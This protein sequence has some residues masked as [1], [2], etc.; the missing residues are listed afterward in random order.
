M[1]S[2]R[3]CRLALGLVL[4]GVAAG[5]RSLPGPPSLLDG[6]LV[7]SPAPLPPDRE[8]AAQAHAFYSIGIHHELAG[9]Y[10]PAYD[11]YRKAAEFDPGNERLVLRMASTL[12]LQRKTED[13]LRAV[14]DFL[15]RNPGSE[16]ALLWLATF[17]GSTGDPARVVELF[18]RMTRQFP[19]KPL[20]WLQLAAA[21]ARAGDT[22]AVEKILENGL[23]KAKPPTA[24]R[25]ELVRIQLARMAAAED[26][27]R[28]NEARRQAIALLRQIAGELPGDMDTLYALGD[29]LV[30]DGQLGEAVL[31]Y[32]KIE[33][34]QPA[35]LQV[36][37][38]LA[39]T[40]LAM[41][42][43]PKA[44]AVLEGLARERESPSNIHYYLAE[45]YLQSG[46]ATN[47]VAH[48]RTAADAS[49]GDPAPW[50][51]LAA[52][53]AEDNEEAAVAT[54]SEA[55]EKMP[56]DPK[57]LEVLALVRQQQKRYE[58]AA[59]LMQQAYDAVVA[60]DPDA[61]P[62]NLFFYNY[63]I[64][65]THLRQ[66]KD[67]AR[68][69]QRASE[70]EPALL[71]LYMQR[72]LTGTGTFRK[73]A[74]GVLRALAKLP[75]TESATIHTHLANLYLSQDRADRAIREFEAAIEIAKKEPLQAT[76]LTPRFYFWFGVA[77][78]Q[79][80]QPERAV[81]MFE[82]CLSLD[83]EYA[84]ALNYLAYLW[85]VRG[86]R[87]DDALGHIQTALALDPENAAYLDTLGWVYYQQGR[88]AD[89]LQLLEQA[90][91]LR[92]EDPEI[93]DHLQKTREKLAP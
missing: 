14:E 66:S 65:C 2:A 20:G 6:G 85:A 48:F 34:L 67:A 51:K 71:E 19:S 64:L 77:L 17:Y 61:I 75:S 10:A 63:A 27:A 23:S 78:D 42:D 31:T 41:D 53:Q 62:S 15:E 28:K 16:G 9:E 57:L 26:P 18:Q 45:L 32:E 80:K 84:D 69:L 3:P 52:L 33:R 5:C 39:R 76:V 55:L 60:K 30:K 68:W 91:A 46:D 83:P 56:G 58:E 90:D 38:R 43:Q 86:E 73:S 40:F 24:L 11:A 74:I 1:R 47:A 82:T 21:T 22:N 8:Q 44:I 89:A 13:A 36:K 49:P 79:A 93:L 81:E 72:T 7:S 4:F 54:L 35:D 92:P 12:V 37:Q 70:Q 88:F 59:G 87:L 29:L 25:Q 50:L